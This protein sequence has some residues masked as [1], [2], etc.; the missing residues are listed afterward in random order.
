MCFPPGCLPRWSPGPGLRR[1]RLHARRG[2]RDLAVLTRAGRRRASEPAGPTPCSAAVCRDPMPSISRWAFHS[3]VRYRLGA[4][5]L[6]STR[7]PTAWSQAKGPACS[8]SNAF[9]DALQH[10]DR[11]Y[12]LVAG[13][14]L[15]NDSRGDLLAP[16]SEGQLRAMRLAYQKAGWTPADVDLIECHATGAPVGDAVEVES[17]K[18]LWGD[19]RLEPRPSA[20]SARSSRISATPLTAAGAAG[21]LKVLLATREP[22]VAAHR[23]FRAGFPQAGARG[24]P[25][26]RAQAARALAERERRDNPDARPSADSGLAASMPMS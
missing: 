6:H 16:S 21:L 18:S 20:R 22:A 12:A 11:I 25:V 8:C 14:G 15:S 19:S 23:E 9:R 4:G 13:V 2:L 10:G 26:S 1:P 3:F 17:L 24:K 7:T 5:R